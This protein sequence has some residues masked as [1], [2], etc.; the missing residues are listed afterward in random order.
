MHEFSGIRVIDYVNGN[1]LALTHVQDGPWRRAVVADRTDEA[2]RGDLDLNGRNVQRDI[3]GGSF[4]RWSV[5]ALRSWRRFQPDSLRILL[6]FRSLICDEQT[7][8]ARTANFKKLSSFHKP[9]LV[10]AEL[11]TKTKSSHVLTDS[12]KRRADAH[13]I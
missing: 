3:R 8:R 7:C 6:R 5:G 12:N 9:S 4:V 11:E 13:R 1:G 2:A 10:R